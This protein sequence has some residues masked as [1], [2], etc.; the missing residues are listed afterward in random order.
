MRERE[1][2]LL[3]RGDQYTELEQKV[4]DSS[5][6]EKRIPETWIID[7]EQGQTQLK[8]FKLN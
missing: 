2:G 3:I 6:D 4:S 8:R 7:E 1:E 5:Q